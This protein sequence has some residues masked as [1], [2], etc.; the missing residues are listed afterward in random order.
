MFE[1][2]LT[3]LPYAPW[4]PTKTTLHLWTQ[5]V[6]KIRLGATPHRN[7]WWNVT[8]VP[9]VRG[10]TT[11]RMRHGETFFELEFDFVAHR[12][13]ARSG[14]GAQAPSFALT[15]G[16]S[17]AE[18]YERTLALLRVLGVDAHILGKPYG[19]PFEAPRFAD[20]H[21]HR[22]YDAGAV[23]RWWDALLW[24]ADV[25]DEFASEFA[26]KQSPAHLF[27]HGFDLAMARFSGAR[28]AGPPK[29]DAV[30][31]EAYSHEVI[32]FGFWPGDAN[33]PGATYYTYTAPEPQT[34]TEFPLHPEPAAWYPQGTGHLGGL[35]YEAVRI[36]TNP[37]A[38]LLEF[39]RSGY[40][41]GTTA[42]PWRAA[43]LASTY[44]SQTV[45]TT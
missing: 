38:T 43:D 27:W 24:T 40:E 33:T 14:D 12:L 31:Q 18:F 36:S 15:D 42:V 21:E 22:S 6:G 9:T 28:A 5:I 2:R 16:T 41:A 3:P 8:L 11:Q 1:S 23:R 45:T 44:R 26:G 34:L 29:T 35:P 39:L 37:R 20:D 4:E 7:H 17:V 13:V 19:I 30:Q 10:L 25:F 32:A